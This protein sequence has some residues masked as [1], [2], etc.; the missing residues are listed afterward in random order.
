MAL[1]KKVMKLL[2]KMRKSTT[3]NTVMKKEEKVIAILFV[4]SR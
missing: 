3:K 1:I 2:P 4:N